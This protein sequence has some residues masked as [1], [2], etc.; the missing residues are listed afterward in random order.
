MAAIPKSDVDPTLD[1]VDRAIEEAEAGKAPRHY[2]GMSGV[3]HP[4]E[5][6]PWL[7]W[8]WITNIRHKA[9]ALKRFHDGH[10]GE[11]LQVKRLRMVPGVELHVIDTETGRQ[12]GFDD[13]DGHFRGHMDGAILGIL[14]A[15]KTWHVYEHK[16]T[17]EKKQAELA[18]LKADKGEK[19]ALEAWD[20]VYYAQAVL[21]MHYSGMKRHYLTC[22]S[23]GG[24][25]T[26]SVRTNENP[27]HAMRLIARAGRMI[28]SHNPP[29]R[30]SDNAEWWQCRLCD[31]RAFCHDGVIERRN[32]RTCLH[33]T[34]VADGQWHCG[35]HDAIR[36][37]NQQLAGCEDHLFLPGLI[38]AEQIDATGESVTYRYP[39]GTEW[40]DG[41]PA[42]A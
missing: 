15:P 31:H 42:S 41:K 9:D 5:R 13:H 7:D 18:K 36:N 8:R 34:P 25:H 17:S 23:P 40:T 14:Q 20:Q 3:G 33:S 37:L 1:A 12:F 19:S 24:R 6:K 38:P 39:D 10:E 26:I 2:L 32:C 28:A 27:E 29:P 11:A 30:I 21:Y 16:Q 35:R 4:C 22:A